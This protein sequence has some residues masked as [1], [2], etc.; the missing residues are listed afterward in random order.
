MRLL[1]K[2]Q[3]E[4]AKP[5]DIYNPSEGGDYTRNR[6]KEIFNILSKYAGRKVGW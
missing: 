3:D 6:Q 4:L 5:A 1:I 2:Y